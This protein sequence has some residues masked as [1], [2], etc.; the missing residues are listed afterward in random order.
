MKKSKYNRREFMK[1]GLAGMAVNE[2]GVHHGL[3]S[4]L[5]AAQTDK[6]SRKGEGRP[7]IIL[8]FTDQQRLSALGAY[9]KT[10]CKTPVL[11]KLAAEGVLFEVT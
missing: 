6:P 7:N 10:V 4:P 3:V 8:F 9:G 2:L 1:A 5:Q 11:D